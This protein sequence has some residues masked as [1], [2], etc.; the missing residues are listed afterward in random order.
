VN[1]WFS[2]SD[3][4]DVRQFNLLLTRDSVDRLRAEGGVCIVS[5]HLGKG[6]ARNGRVDPQVTDTLRYIATLPGWFA[7]VSEILEHFRA[8]AVRLERPH[9]V[10][11]RQEIR[12]VVDRARGLG[13]PSE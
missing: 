13:R 8:A 6:F 2:T 1:C 3:A 11:A 5:T 10:Q 12:H 4:A 9:L 7:P